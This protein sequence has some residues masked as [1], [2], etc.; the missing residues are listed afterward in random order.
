MCLTWTRHLCFNKFLIFFLNK[1][2]QKLIVFKIW[3][4]ENVFISVIRGSDLP[5]LD[6]SGLSDPYVVVSLYP[7]TMF[8][9]NK[10]Q[11]T[12]VIDQTLNPVFNTTFQL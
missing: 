3:I 7:K 5:G 11:R 4:S 12:K 2:S 10:P 1:D 6:H 9:H 8:G